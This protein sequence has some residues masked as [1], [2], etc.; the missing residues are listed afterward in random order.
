M[1]SPSTAPRLAIL[2]LCKIWKEHRR[3]AFLFASWFA[4]VLIGI[5]GF[6]QYFIQDGGT[7]PRFLSLLY[8]SLQLFT[9]ESGGLE[10]SVPLALQ[11][12]R[13]VAPAIPLWAIIEVFLGVFR[14]DLRA[15]RLRLLRGHII[16]CGDTREAGALLENACA[17]GANVVSLSTTG[18][19]G[20]SLT[21]QCDN[22]WHV[23]GDPE[24][25]SAL[26]E[27]GV[28]FSNEVYILGDK[29]DANIRTALRIDELRATMA[30][31]PM[32]ASRIVLQVQDLA[33]LE[34]VTHNR[35][36]GRQGGT[37]AWHVTNLHQTAARQLFLN[38]P[39]DYEPIG[40][41]DPRRV[42]L[43]LVGFDAVGRHVAIQAAK[44]GHFANGKKLRITVLDLDAARK[45]AEFLA[46]HDAI[47]QVCDFEVFEESPAFTRELE[48]IREWTRDPSTL[49]SLVVAL[50][51]D[52]DCV[53]CAIRNILN[54]SDLRSPVYV[55]LQH[56]TQLARLVTECRQD[57]ELRPTVL[58]FGSLRAICT[59]EAI[60]DEP[61]DRLAKMIHQ[62]Y[63][64]E[65]RKEDISPEDPSLQ[66][67]DQLHPS[68]QEANRQ[69]ADTP[70]RQNSAPSDAWKA[71]RCPRPSLPSP[72][73]KSTSS[74]KMEHP[75]MGGR[76]HLE[77]LAL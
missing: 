36:L 14:N 51:D 28:A 25:L 35:V 48:R 39:L 18:K 31:H 15:L 6:Y 33:L 49:S 67:W 1:K 29:D 54:I 2:M 57:K 13:F 4:T 77:R 10:G 21:E 63:V 45:T 22:A 11:L 50:E 9:L 68:K 62:A 34:M 47:S 65:R 58:P 60:L 26:Q 7:S 27:A 20:G 55:R 44:V 8:F 56:R 32:L 70:R 3:W 19:A 59:R 53:K 17:D 41:E 52:W 12:A 71:R 66:S 76:A 75:P 43:I 42:H 24:S 46:E 74:P 69:Q 64:R 23:V 61:M 38:N 30:R 5:F 40:A 72:M 37:R 16:V 73:R